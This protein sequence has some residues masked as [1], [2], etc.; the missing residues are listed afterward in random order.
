M[1]KILIVEDNAESRYMLEQL[2][3]SK[4]H[5]IITAENGEDAL[6]LAR[7]NPPEVIISDIMMP[8]M[9]GFRLCRE[10]K[11]DASLRNIPFIFYTATFVEKADE[12]PAMSLGASRFVVKP[13]E[14]EQFMQ[15]LDG[16]LDEHRQGVLSVPEKPLEGEN[17]LPEMYDN[18]VARKLAETVEKLQDERKALIKS[19]QRLKEAQE[20]AQMGHWELDFKSNSLECSDEIYRILGLK[21]KEFDAS[22]EAFMA[23]VHPEDRA[24]VTRAHEESLAK[25]TQCDI[26]CRVL[27]KDGTI[28]YVIERFQTIYDDIGMPTCL[29]GTVQDITERKRTETVLRESE[30]QYRRLVENSLDIIFTLSTD[31]KFSSLNPAFET[32]TG[33]SRAEFLGKSFTP[34]IHPDDLPLAMEILQSVLQGETPPIFELRVLSKSGEHIVG[35][36][37]ATPQIQKGKVSGL[38]GIARD[39]TKLK[40]V[41]EDLRK[42]EE[43][44]RAMFDNMMNGVAVYR[45]GNNGKDFIFVDFN[46]SAERME[47]IRK[48]DLVGKSVLKVFSSVKDFGL[49]DV[50][51]RV[52]KTGK[53]ESHPVTQYKDE[54][55]SVWRENFVYKLPSGEIVSV[56][57]DETERKQAEEALREAESLYRLHFENVSDIIYSVDRELKVVN[58]SPSVEHVLGYKP[59]EMI[60]RPFQDLNVLAPDSLEQAASDTL[61]VLGGERI[62]S[63]EYRFITRDGTKKWSEVSGAPLIRD[64][65]VVGVISVAR[66]VTDRKRMEEALRQSEYGLSIRNRIN[67]IFLT[68][69]GE[70]MYGEVLKVVLEVMESKYGIFGYINEDGAWVCPSMTRDIWDE[71][72]IP[73]K[74]IILAKD[75]WGGIWGRAMNEKKTLYSNNSFTVPQGHILITRALDVPIIY[76]G[77]LIGNLLVGNKETNYGEKDIQVLE[78][79][80]DKIAPVLHSTLQIEKQERE[81]KQ[82]EAQLIQ[83]QKMEAVGTLAGGVAHDFNNLLT[84]IIG[85]AGLVL[86]ALGKDHPLREGIGDIKKAGERG[87]ALTRQLLAFSR[88]QVIK[89]E[90]LDLNN[91][92]NATEKML[93]RMIAE[94][95]E[96][97]TVLKPELWKVHMDSGQIEQIIINLAVNARDAMP[98]GGK[99]IVETA[100]VDLDKNYLREHGIEGTPGHYVMLAISDTGIGMNKETQEHI[101]E[102]F[103]TTKEIDKGTG[104]GLSTVYGIVKQNKG[105]IWVYSEPGKGTTFKN[106]LPKVKESVEAEKKEQTP[107]VD[108]NGSETVLIVED[109]D[110][111]RKLAQ[112]TL[113]PHGYRVLAAEN[114][115]DALRVSAEHEG[116]IDLIITDVVMPKMGGKEVAERLQPIYPHMKVIY[117]SGYTDN[118]IVHYGV[119]APGLNFLEKPFSPAGLARKVREVLDAEN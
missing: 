16:V 98:Q 38:L 35:Q 75:Q 24:Y 1:S 109:D 34:I 68:I 39:I 103:F 108:L 62:P 29:M 63:S 13:T 81:K 18:S 55:I 41:N 51:Q 32:I 4:G 78:N 70:E 93:K 65:Q 2:L 86:T 36:F 53:P 84:T 106:Y 28:K 14:E 87:A 57:N 60:G 52:W 99:L 22:Y 61:R 64:G 114:G 97:K 116:T 33:W 82:L 21:P 49:F 5:H 117:M 66:D 100:N 58:I 20:L 40:K 42:S 118:S 83:S 19:E 110:S 91:V 95:V 115:E 94:D 10:V 85:N 101:F 54:R 43:R 119:L 12:K 59:E 89:P 46:K 44:Y 112:K 26:E 31:G 25:K 69:P 7:Q 77:E 67:E 96:F 30:R 23:F 56:Y 27:L 48:E 113:Q 74:A 50:F 17:I 107:K 111:L 73:D 80:A 71:C 3:V 92:I 6:R 104:L 15:I 102:P 47:N 79:I 11:K 45:T 37:T 9:N 76:Q 8:V 105:F 90:V 88:K 72:R